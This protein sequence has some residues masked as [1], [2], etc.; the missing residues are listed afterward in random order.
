MRILQYKNGSKSARE[1]STALGCLRLTREGSRFRNNYNHA[2]INWGCSSFDNSFPVTTWINNPEA[3]GRASNK[4]SC[5]RALQEKI[6]DNIPE[7]ATSPQD[8]DWEKP[9]V[10]RHRLTGHSGEG[11]EIVPEGQELP[12]APLYVK[13]I[14]KSKEFRAHVI[15]GRVVDVQEKRKR[16]DVENDLVDYRVRNSSNGWV[17][18]RDS[19]NYGDQLVDIAVDAVDCLGLDFGAVDI[20]YNRHYDKYYVLEVNTACGMEGSTVTS[21]ANHI[22]RLLLEKGAR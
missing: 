12:R 19:V 22:R 5:F 6:P 7:F 8:V 11:I 16:R 14:K 2:I 21:Y 9:T 15:N 20:I 3:V 13:Y 10:V 18:C 1:L 17:Y 4:L